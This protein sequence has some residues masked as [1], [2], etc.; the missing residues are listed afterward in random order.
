MGRWWSLNKKRKGVEKLEK[1]N[2]LLLLLLFF[3]PS[4]KVVRNFPPLEARGLPEQA[5]E[6]EPV[7]QLAQDAVAVV[8]L[9]CFL[10]FG[11]GVL[12]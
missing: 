12:F 5:G 4:G 3:L 7:D 10:D 8:R 1:K 2:S 6:L 11:V 9:F